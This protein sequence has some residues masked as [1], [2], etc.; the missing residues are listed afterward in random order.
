MK[1]F[2]PKG[3]GGQ[4]QAEGPLSLL[5]TQDGLDACDAQGSHLAGLALNASLYALGSAV[6][7]LSEV[8]SAPAAVSSSSMDTG[9]QQAA[10]ALSSNSHIALLMAK[11][12]STPDNNSACNQT[13]LNI[14]ST[15]QSVAAS[16]A[17]AAPAGGRTAR[18][19]HKLSCQDH[20]AGLWSTAETVDKA[21]HSAAA[22]S[23]STQR[24]AR[25]AGESVRSAERL[26]SRKHNERFGKCDEVAVQ[27]GAQRPAGVVGTAPSLFSFQGP[28]D[29]HWIDQD[30]ASLTRTPVRLKARHTIGTESLGSAPAG[31]LLWQRTTGREPDGL[32]GHDLRKRVEVVVVMEHGRDSVLGGGRQEIVDERQ[33]LSTVGS[34]SKGA[35]GILGGTDHARCHRGDSQSGKL[36]RELVEDRTVASAVQNL[37]AS[38]RSDPKAIS[39]QGSIPVV[40]NLGTVS[41]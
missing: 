5:F 27:R 7:S 28:V 19:I 18:H 12:V 26:I 22:W 2:R 29:E 41:S 20:P 25:S 1:S 8:S 32:E 40:A 6:C 24:L 14:R 38:G 16:S 33:S 4:A 21:A 37:E 13:F 17:T 36:L 3:I 35:H 31:G 34:V 39:L 9:Q 30:A 10:G 11:P 15:E 23:S